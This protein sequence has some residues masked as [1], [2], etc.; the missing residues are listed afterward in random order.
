[1]QEIRK[2]IEG[3]EGYYQVSNLGRV[4]SVDR[5]VEQTISKNKTTMKIRKSKILSS[6]KMKNGYL[7]VP[8][9]KKGKTK[10][11]FVHRLVAQTFIPNQLNKPQVNHINGIKNDNRVVNLE[12]ATGLENIRH[13]FKNHLF[14]KHKR[15]ILKIKDDKIIQRYESIADVVR[16]L[17]L[18]NTGQNICLVAQGKR[19]SAYGYQRKYI[20]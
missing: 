19:K 15:P 20:D 4:K 17:G 16:E 7:K 12:W 5:K 10:L 13:G 9:S 1:M 6:T 8:L 18:N 14:D 11:Q 2:D 3:Y